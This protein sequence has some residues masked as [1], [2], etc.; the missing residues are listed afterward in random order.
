MEGSHSTTWAR[1]GFK[2]TLLGRWD[3]GHSGYSDLVSARC[4][5]AHDIYVRNLRLTSYFVLI[6]FLNFIIVKDLPGIIVGTLYIGLC[7]VRNC[8]KHPCAWGTFS[9]DK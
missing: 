8:S 2:R 4:H 7:S 9:F 5:L 3:H 6:S 1:C